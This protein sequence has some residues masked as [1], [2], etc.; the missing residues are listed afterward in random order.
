MALF[1]PHNKKNMSGNNIS[2]TEHFPLKEKV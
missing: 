2:K 1:V